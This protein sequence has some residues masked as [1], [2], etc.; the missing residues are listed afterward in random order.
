MGTLELNA[1]EPSGRSTRVTVTPATTPNETSGEAA[2]YGLRV[3]QVLEPEVLVNTRRSIAEIKEFL[4]V[5]GLEVPPTF[6]EVMPQLRADTSERVV[7]TAA[8]PASQESTQVPLEA[9]AGDERSSREEVSYNVTLRSDVLTSLEP[10]RSVTGEVTGFR[11]ARGNEVR[12]ILGVELRVNAAG[13]EVYSDVTRHEAMVACGVLQVD[14]FTQIE[15]SRESV[16]ELLCE[17]A[18]FCGRLEQGEML[19]LEHRRS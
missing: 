2:R 1:M 8:Q 18:S 19:C 11:D 16:L 12:F 5:F 6:F 7:F 9:R 10:M 17:K 15:A 4:E 13:V 3:E 14:G